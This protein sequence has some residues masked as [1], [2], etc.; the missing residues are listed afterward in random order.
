[1]RRSSFRCVVSMSC[2]V[3]I[4]AVGCIITTSNG[5]GSGSATDGS[6][7]TQ[8]S[9][10]SS[11]SASSGSPTTASSTSDSDPTTDGTTTGLPED[12]GDNLIGD[13]GFEAGTPNP[14]WAE[15]STIFGTPICDLECT[16]DSGAGP[17]QGSWWVWFGGLEEPDTASVSQV[18]TIPPDAAYLAFFFEINAAQGE[19]GDDVVTVE[20]DDTTVFMAT[21]AELD[22]YASYTE[23]VVDVSDFADGEQHTVAIRAEITGA[24]LTNFFVDDVTL[25]SCSEGSTTTD[26]SGTTDPT[27]TGSTTED[28]TGS[29]TDETEGTTGTTTDTTGTTGATTTTTAG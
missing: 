2:W 23:V 26:T 11:G 13:P 29:T 21:D 27:S 1:M 25:V 14:S 22:D 16:E 12:C 15:A 19:I 18:V 28:T 6:A 8:T 20:I 10:P 4:A 3:P 7:T 17:H 24:G 9:S 5:D